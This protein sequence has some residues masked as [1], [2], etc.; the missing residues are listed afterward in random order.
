MTTRVERTYYV[1]SAL[2]NLSW[3]FLGAVYP[4]FLLSRG[5]DLFQINAILAV[6]FV[7]NFLFE[8]PTGAIADLFGRKVSFLASCV[9]RGLAFVAYY[10]SE[11]FPGWVGSEILD[12]LG[13]T[14]A[15]GALDAWAVDEGR[16]QGD[17]RP[18]DRLFARSR[19]LSYSA[20]IVSGLAGGYVGEVDI[21]YPWLVGVGGFALTA[22]VAAAAMSES[23]PAASRLRRSERSLLSR[24][25][26][27][28]VLQQQIRGGL[29][30][31]VRHPTLRHLCLLTGLIA[32][33]V[34]PFLQLW[35][36]Q[37]TALSGAGTSLMGWVWAGLNVASLLGSGLLPRLLT[38]LDRRAAIIGLC[39]LRAAGVLLAAT[40]F[41]FGRAL[42]GLLTQ[43]LG[44]GASDPMLSAWT[45]E[46]A[47][48][49]QRATVLSVQTMSF[50]LGGSV[51]LLA[52]G[53]IASLYGISVAWGFSSAVFLAGAGVAWRSAHGRPS[54]DPRAV[55]EP[56]PRP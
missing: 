38:R 46:H 1:V 15:S 27:I 36:P 25:N 42:A 18:A 13:T 21:A 45:N 37:M 4:L 39:V 51:G 49:E 31:V 6:Y 44:M 54:E 55:A 40:S 34:M 12:A 16:L 47:S 30:T 35:P 24:L 32:F 56:S 14:L 43:S 9:I 22:A 17:D 5:L 11:S 20:M 29:R 8:V 7:A 23:R 3:A 41:G 33:A 10:H 52:I 48:S 53:E 28:P 26:P 50:M 2:Y 19:G